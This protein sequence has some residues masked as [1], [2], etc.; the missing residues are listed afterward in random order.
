MAAINEVDRALE[1]IGFATANDRNSIREE[2]GL[3]TLSDFIDLTEKDLKDMANSFAKRTA[4]QGRINFG[5][6]RI[7]L[8]LGIMHW[9]QDK[10]R[11]SRGASVVGIADADS[12][13]AE[14]Q[15]SIKRAALRQTEAEQVDT[16]SKAADPGKFKDERKWPDWEP[17][18]V[19]YLSTI[20]GVYSV[21]LSYVVRENDEPDHETDFGDDFTREM[22]AGASLT[23]THFKADA[24]KVHQLLKN[25]LV[26]ETAEQWI[27]DI[28]KYSDGRR[29][30]KALRSHYSGEGNA[31]RRIAIA[32]RMRE[33]LHYKNERLLSFSLFLDKMQRMFNIFKDEGE[34]LTEGAKVRELLKRVEHPYLKDTVKA[35]EVRYDIEGLSY[36]EAANHITS[37]VSRLPEYTSTRKVSA[38]QSYGDSDKSRSGSKRGIYNAAGK[39]HTGF[40][41]NWRKLSD[42]EKAKVIAERKKKSP[43]TKTTGLGIKRKASELAVLNESMREVKRIISD[44]QSK[45]A[46]SFSSDTK[47]GDDSVPDDAGNAF[48][49]RKAKKSNKE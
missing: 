17:A 9:V 16:I 47:N 6:R 19:N 44:I 36:T 7:K 12:F 48:G 18:F 32:E 30:M 33:S 10:D 37:A 28:S 40:Y 26:A 4:A 38:A 2:G 23:G 41:K 42:E 15:V 46:V 49:G 5:M 22:V 20:P 21:P 43:L 13:K 31:S 3:E 14:L 1:W 35:L 34:E 8:I 45:K 27:K 39:I 24:R 25:F 29:D 11:C